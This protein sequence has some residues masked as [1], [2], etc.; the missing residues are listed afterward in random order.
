MKIRL[1]IIGLALALTSGCAMVE[2]AMKVGVRLGL[3]AGKEWAEAQIGAI[4]EGILDKAEEIANKGIDKAMIFSAEN[5]AKAIDYGFFVALKA[6]GVNPMDFDANGDGKLS[7]AERLAALEAARQDENTPWYA[8]ILLA[9]AGTLFTTGKS[10]RRYV[11]DKRSA[12]V[13]AKVDEVLEN[14]G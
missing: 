3:D 1:T 4:P 7:E 10:L 12:E 8:G 2:N 14:G 5:S 11:G 9:I 6:A 13:T